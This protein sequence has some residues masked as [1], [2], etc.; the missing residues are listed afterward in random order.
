MRRPPASNGGEE[1]QRQRQ[2]QTERRAAKLREATQQQRAAA[3]ASALQAVRE[4]RA[5]G[6]DAREAAAA[7]VASVVRRASG[8]G[9]GDRG[10]GG[11][12]VGNGNSNRGGGEQQQQQQNKL[13][14]FGGPSLW[15]PD[16]WAD[17][18]RE[19]VEETL[20]EEAEEHQRSEAAALD[21]LVATHQRR[22]GGRCI[23]GTGGDE[24]FARSSSAACS[25]LPSAAE[26]A[27]GSCPLCGVKGAL[28]ATA[29]GALACSA[30]A[31]G[32]DGGGGD[33]CCRFSVSSACG[34]GNPAPTSQELASAIRGAEQAHAAT[35]CP[36][37]APER[38]LMN[39][40][41]GGGS[42]G[43][44]SSAVLFVAC[45]RCGFLEAAL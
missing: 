31:F 11:G 21:E 23:V 45:R 40:E 33:G 39:S 16:E 37:A 24:S 44:S 43:P 3:R 15:D 17:L 42:G 19:I 27:A 12:G 10:G 9:D 34:P 29:G 28:A 5:R 20:A 4:A 41:G 1:E 25:S 32:N 26:V 35:G 36:A 38:T 7:A 8:S 18:E 13:E 2:Q 22:E 30:F 6:G 14:A